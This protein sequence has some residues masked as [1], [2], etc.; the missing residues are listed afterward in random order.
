[1]DVIDLVSGNETVRY[2]ML[3]VLALCHW[4][5]DE[6]GFHRM[7]LAHSVANVASCRGATKAGFRAER[8]RREAA[9]HPDG[10]HDMHQRALLA[11]DQARAA[12]AL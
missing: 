12:R 5:F 6:S 8:V 3:F 4:A 9:R 7:G 2:R 10:W 11:G 1:M